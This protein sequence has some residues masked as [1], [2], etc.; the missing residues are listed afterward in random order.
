MSPA[1]TAVSG[2]R[3]HAASFVQKWREFSSPRSP[4]TPWGL[5]RIAFGLLALMWSIEVGQ[6]LYDRFGATRFVPKTSSPDYLWS[7]FHAVPHAT[8]R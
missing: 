8:M 4:P 6:D 2:I 1:S 7:I 5:V 3:E